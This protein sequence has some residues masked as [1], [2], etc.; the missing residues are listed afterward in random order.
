MD[1]KNLK[2]LKDVSYAVDPPIMGGGIIRIIH[3][4]S[5]V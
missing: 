3:T 5:E 4:I 2:N 1:A